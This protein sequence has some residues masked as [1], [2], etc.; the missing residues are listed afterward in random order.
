M[1]EKIC[2]LVLKYVEKYKGVINIFYFF[3]VLYV[4]SKKLFFL[5]DGKFRDKIEPIIAEIMINLCF[6]KVNSIEEIKI[7]IKEILN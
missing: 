2:G 3:Y 6:Y 5:Y 1:R 7:F 4:L